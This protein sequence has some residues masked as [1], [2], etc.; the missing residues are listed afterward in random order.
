MLAAREYGAEFWT[1]YTRYLRKPENV[2]HVLFTLAPRGDDA[3]L[4][5]DDYFQQY[6]GYL[7]D[8]A[9]VQDAK[10]D[11]RAK[12]G[13][14]QC[15]I[16]HPLFRRNGY[17]GHLIGQVETYMAHDEGVQ[18]LYMLAQLQ[19]QDE[20]AALN[21]RLATPNEQQVMRKYEGKEL[22]IFGSC[23]VFIRT[24]LSDPSNL[25]RTLWCPPPRFTANYCEAM[26]AL[27]KPIIQGE[28]EDKVNMNTKAV[29][30]PRGNE[31]KK[32]RVPDTGKHVARGLLAI[33]RVV[34]HDC[35]RAAR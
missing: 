22:A 9:I 6:A 24:Y 33:K 2:V 11:S 7:V 17:S 30:N 8:L 15:H 1:R 10:A 3:A 20:L 32:Y 26:L 18:L 35:F 5:V 21:F 16:S 19:D 29:S 12:I 27:S 4:E 25:H 28:A 23:L 13:I 14:V 34:E 31:A